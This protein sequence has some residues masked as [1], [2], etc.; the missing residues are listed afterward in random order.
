MTIFG[1]GDVSTDGTMLYCISPNQE[2]HRLHTEGM[3]LYS[4]MKEKKYK[5]NDR[6]TR[7]DAGSKDKI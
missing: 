2:S 7:R 1:E 4:S 3:L 5:E 6:Q